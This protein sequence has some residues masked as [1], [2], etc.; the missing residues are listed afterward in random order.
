MRTT[1]VCVGYH[2][3]MAESR[4]PLLVEISYDLVMED[5]MGA[6]EGTYRLPGRDWQV[7]VCHPSRRKTPRVVPYRWDSGITGL[8]VWMPVETKINMDSIERV[9]SDVLGVDQWSRIRGPDSIR[10]R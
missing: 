2:A 7:W 6:A 10:L 8:A 9:L 5:D 1:G 4:N 3:D